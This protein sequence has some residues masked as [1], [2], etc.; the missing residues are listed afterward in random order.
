MIRVTF[1]FCFCF[2][3]VGSQ[4]YWSV[5]PLFT[6]FT[7]R[8]WMQNT[9]ILYFLQF[10]I[11]RFWSEIEN[12]IFSLKGSHQLCSLSHTENRASL[13]KS[14]TPR[15][16]TVWLRQTL[17]WESRF[18]IITYFGKWSGDLPESHTTSPFVS[19]GSWNQPRCSCYVPEPQ[20]QLL[21][22]ARDI[23]SCARVQGYPCSKSG[24]VAWH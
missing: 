1:F 6:V 5:L 2:L 8:G 10:Y 14:E 23:C 15:V 17:R 13:A 21:K 24:K 18:N 12:F 7:T 20:A 22:A 19:T 16:W 4:G 11:F 3:R 9:T